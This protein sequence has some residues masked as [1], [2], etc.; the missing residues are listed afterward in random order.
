LPTKTYVPSSA[1]DIIAAAGDGDLP[2]VQKFI[3]ANP[4]CVLQ[5]DL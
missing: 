5:E 3:C 1:A 4:A 2:L